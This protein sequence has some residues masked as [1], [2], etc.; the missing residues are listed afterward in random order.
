VDT[1]SWIRCPANTASWDDAGATAIDIPYEKT[2][3]EM[4]GEAEKPWA[5]EYVETRTVDKGTQRYAL[6]TAEDSSEGKC[7]K[8]TFPKHW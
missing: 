4:R 8:H 7:F 6:S 3:A 2:A 5:P 1:S